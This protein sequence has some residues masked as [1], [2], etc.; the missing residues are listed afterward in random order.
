[1]NGTE[2]FTESL[3]PAD[4]GERIGDA[5]SSWFAPGEGAPE[6]AAWSVRYLAR[7]VEVPL[8]DGPGVLALEPGPYALMPDG[9]VRELDRLRAA[10]GADQEPAALETGRGSVLTE[11]KVGAWLAID[12]AGDGGAA[13]DVLEGI[14]RT[15][16]GQGPVGEGMASWARGERPEAS[17]GARPDA[18]TVRRHPW[19][20]DAV[21]RNL[22]TYAPGVEHVEDVAGQHETCKGKDKREHRRKVLVKVR[23][24]SP[25]SELD[26]EVHAAVA[27]LWRRG[28]RTFTDRQVHAAITG[29]GRKGWADPASVARI[30]GSVAHQAGIMV[31]LDFS[32]EL[33][34]SRKRTFERERMTADK[35]KLHQRM[36]EVEEVGLAGGGTAWRIAEAPI[37]YKHAATFHQVVEV[38]QSLL[39]ASNSSVRPTLRNSMIR[40]YLI[41][42]IEG[43]KNRRNGLNSRCI[44]F[45]SLCRAVGEPDPSR[46]VRDSIIKAAMGYLAFF[47]EVGYIE[48]AGIYLEHD[49]THRRNGAEIGLYEDR[50]ADLQVVGSEGVPRFR[51]TYA[52]VSGHLCLGFGAGPRGRQ[53]QNSC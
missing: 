50:R 15:A 47:A 49:Y 46:K 27:A 28:V 37:F 13:P 48:D 18:R 29:R 38:D 41:A 1:M 5:L 7:A 23:V 34:G 42:R 16:Y 53:I 4:A 21:W 12:A 25:V 40:A 43:M 52:E 19:P 17:G 51:G 36:L 35:C 3:N 24:S 2:S 39:T 31:D 20:T 9:E 14:A 6:G 8:E 44:N 45:D 33:R 32:A 10:V 30:H 26:K 11:A 22:S